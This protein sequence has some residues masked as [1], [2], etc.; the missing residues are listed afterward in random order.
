MVVVF[1][2]RS[3]LLQMDSPL[4]IGSVGKS[5]R[6]DDILP[7]SLLRSFSNPPLLPHCTRPTPVVAGL[8]SRFRAFRVICLRSS[9][10]SW[11]PPLP[12]PARLF[13]GHLADFLP[14]ISAGLP[15]RLTGPLP[16]TTSPSQRL[17]PLFR[18]L[19]PRM[20]ARLNFDAKKDTVPPS[21][22]HRF[23]LAEKKHSFTFFLGMDSPQLRVFWSS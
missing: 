1:S 6:F 13:L 14:A 17:P 19:G 21:F 4:V 15:Y 5:C 8:I 9:F 10:P 23:A 11:P 2:R 12:S 22:F 7:E 20:F 18:C 16:G 3:S